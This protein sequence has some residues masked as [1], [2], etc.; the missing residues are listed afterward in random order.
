MKGE[1][2]AKTKAEMLHAWEWICDH[3]GKNNFVSSIVAEMP[4]E[5]RL[6]FAKDHGMVEEYVTEVPDELKEGD[7]MTFPTEVTCG[8]C[9]TDYETEHEYEDE[10]ED[11]GE[12]TSDEI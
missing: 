5:D 4:P 7:F 11:D 8:H 6:Q 1:T 10:D 2:V 12:S 3:C 9:G